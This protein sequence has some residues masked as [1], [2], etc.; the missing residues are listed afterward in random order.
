MKLREAACSLLD[1]VDVVLG[2]GGAFVAQR[3][4]A[5][6][7]ERPGALGRVRFPVSK[8]GPRH[9]PREQRQRHDDFVMQ[10]QGPRTML[11]VA[12]IN[13]LRRLIVRVARMTTRRTALDVT[14]SG[15]GM[16]LA[17]TTTRPH[18]WAAGAV[19]FALVVMSAPASAAERQ[20]GNRDRSP[21]D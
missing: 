6:P 5:R 16:T 20:C 17:R 8:A 13:R 21:P 19:A 9:P 3:H 11:R 18:V 2:V 14:G 15:A 4:V 10:P 1:I 12:K 7:S